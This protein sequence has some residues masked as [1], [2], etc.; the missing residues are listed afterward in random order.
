MTNREQSLFTSQVARQA[1][2]RSM[3]QLGILLL[4][5][6]SDASPSQGY[7]PALC[8]QGYP[9]RY[10]CK[11]TSQRY[12]CKATPSVMIADTHLFTWVK[13]LRKQHDGRDQAE[14]RRSDT[15]TARPPHLHRLE[16]K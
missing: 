11:A 9:Q 7:P 14:G 13:C 8:S 2:F 4:L 1:G 6:G 5:P 15:L 16:V 12:D 10:D 3:K